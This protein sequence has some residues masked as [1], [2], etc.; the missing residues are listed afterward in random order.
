[1]EF[2]G[3]I[4]SQ[5]KIRGYRVEL[6]E[7]ESRLLTHE[8][9]KEAAVIVYEPIPGGKHLCAYYVPIQGEIT[10]NPPGTLEDM[11]DNALLR[12][13]LTVSLPDYMLPSYFV[14]I[15]KIPLTPNGKLNR[16][17]LPEPKPLASIT[18]YT[19]PRDRVEETLVK[20]WQEILGPSAVRVGID[21]E[22]FRLGG[23]SLNAIILVSKIHKH[24]D[25][26]VSL[27][28]IFQFSTIR[29]LGL[30]LKGIKS[31]DKERY[32]AI[33]PV[34]EKEYYPL[35]SAQQRLFVLHQ[36]SESGVVYN[37]MQ[38]L[39]LQG[40]I[41]R[42]RLESVFKG[43]IA[44]HESLRT[45]FEIIEGRAVQRIH[46]DV[47][48]QIE[49]F[50]PGFEARDVVNNFIHSFD[51]SHA[52][53][54]RVGLLKLEEQRHLLMIDM[55]HIISDA[56]SR[57][58]VTGDFIALYAGDVLPDLTIS[59]KDYALW[60]ARAG[61]KEKRKRREDFWKKTFDGEPAVLNLP[62]DYARPSIQNF[63]GSQY[64]FNLGAH[65]T[66]G[67]KQL[68]FE[69]NATLYM[70]LLTIYNILLSKLSGKEDII[71]GT[72][73]AGRRHSDLD[74]IMGMFVNT[75]AL[76]NYPRDKKNALQF[77]KEVRENTLEAFENQDYPFEEL[78]ELLV[79]DR[80]TSRNPLFDVVFALQNTENVSLQIPGITI[81]PC[82]QENRT[83][84]FDLALIGVETPQGLQFVLEY[85]TA[86]FKAETIRRFTRYFLTLI[87]QVLANPLAAI[88]ELEILSLEEKQRILVD[89]N[90]TRTDY[91]SDRTIHGLF[92]EQ[93][94][95]TPDHVALVGQIANDNTQITKKEDAFISYRQLDYMANGLARY[96]TGKGVVSGTIVAI[97][98]PRS[99]EMVIGILGILK[100]G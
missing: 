46:K 86:L 47:S 41:D 12:E 48:F 100:A 59:Y 81:I 67:L 68:A 14:P 75:L 20:L 91:P 64:Q 38:L 73:I 71:I 57:N 80:D 78:V 44:R 79:I 24:L 28:N 27:T 90:D 42:V 7:I 87:A 30:H 11:P 96:L 53:L 85:G 3:R 98:L 29:S 77:L 17:L 82:R 18:D 65:E 55:H 8:A 92:E 22:F 35:S 26:A 33:E 84:K 40:N 74:Q 95:R 32:A 2:L 43:L 83:S 54:L 60:Q 63:E 70:V 66:A 9:V 4:D 97:M 6:G 34:E 19:A 51:L 45:S 76:R 37:M 94:K 31:P 23:H 36:L 88:S 50:A 21:D 56:V 99:L 69:S 89:F 93:A 5:V 1:M 39:E 10:T 58:I 72:P 62:T 25:M 49:Y 61:E 16:K 13:H 52:P 15:E